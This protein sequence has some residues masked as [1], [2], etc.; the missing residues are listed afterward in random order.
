MAMERYTDT[1]KIQYSCTASLY[2]IVKVKVI[3]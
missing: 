3:F 2:F 1:K